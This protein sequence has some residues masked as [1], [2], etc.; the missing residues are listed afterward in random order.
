[1]L[2]DRNAMKGEM[3]RRVVYGSNN[4]T[5]KLTKEYDIEGMIRPK[6]RPKREEKE[7]K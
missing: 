5:K 1:M 4:F 7:S 3:E 6:G 2:K